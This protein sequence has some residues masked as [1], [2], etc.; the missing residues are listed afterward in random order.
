MDSEFIFG[1]VIGL[2]FMCLYYLIKYAD[3]ITEWWFDRK[4]RKKK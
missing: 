4:N 3:D 1:F 2:V